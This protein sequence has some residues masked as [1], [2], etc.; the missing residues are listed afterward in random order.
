MC[1][2]QKDINSVEW[3]VCSVCRSRLSLLTGLSTRA[4]IGVFGET[5]KKDY[6]CEI[7]RTRYM[8]RENRNSRNQEA[9]NDLVPENLGTVPPQ[10]VELEEAVL[11]ALIDRKSVV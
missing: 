2:F 9:Y 1:S 4:R 6:I 5:E 3:P 8:A 7:I 10:A 11:G